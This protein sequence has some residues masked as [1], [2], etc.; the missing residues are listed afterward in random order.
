MENLTLKVMKESY[1]DIQNHL[2]HIRVY[3]SRTS[4]VEES[5]H[6]RLNDFKPDKTL[7]E[8]DNILDFNLQEV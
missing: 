7:S 6:V 8:Q 4:L 2:R 1:L 3:N 5:I